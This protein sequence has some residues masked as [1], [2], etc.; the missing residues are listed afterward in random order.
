[1]SGFGLF[2]GNYVRQGYAYRW[3]VLVPAVVVF[4]LATVHVAMQPDTYES[5]AILM[6]PM[7]NSADREMRSEALSI[8]EDVFRSATERLTSKNVL[9][10]IS[11]QTDPYP[12]LR[13]TR[14]M[15]AVVE[16][17][18]RNLRI[19]VN[20]AAR[21]ITILCSQSD[22]DNAAEMAANV[23]KA[24]TD[25]FVR[26]QR[27]AIQGRVNELK[28]YYDTELARH[29]LSLDRARNARDEFK[30]QNAGA[31][32]DDRAANNVRIDGLKR[33]ISDFRL[34]KEA[35]EL[36][37]VVLEGDQKRLVT[38]LSIATKGPASVQSRLEQYE[39]DLRQARID[40]KTLLTVYQP[41]HERVLAA[42]AMIELLE[43]MLENARKKEQDPVK[44][45]T[46]F[47]NSRLNE[48]ELREK[49]SRDQLVKLDGRIANAEK[50]IKGLEAK[51][52]RA[53]E[54]E[55]R[56]IT[57][58]QTV[59]E[60]QFAYDGIVRRQNAAEQRARFDTFASMIPVQ[61]EQNAFV[62]NKP[63]RPDR[64]VTSVMGL[65]MGVGVGVGLAVVRAKLDNSYNRPDDLRSLLPG[66]VLVTVPDVRQGGTRL[67]LMVIG[68]LGGLVLASL[69][70]ATIGLLGL[71]IG[72]WGE[73][74]MVRDLMSL[75]R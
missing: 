50:E 67:G 27:D 46:D 10:E 54:I 9:Q 20:S 12:L 73:P 5:H 49:S 51:V 33:D 19:D 41:E 6:R 1:M 42:K 23:V 72:W 61:V 70:A 11:R 37:I 4:A 60:A 65:L 68:I 22:G 58:Q 62:P 40:H 7:A 47:L 26:Q 39:A 36:R 48:L 15:D 31:L 69:F 35:F 75:G 55:G 14:G 29:R 56:Y 74:E 28:H 16:R 43:A 71:Q 52:A 2:V 59:D 18:R 57:L 25:I 63:T 32:P 44:N 13:E 53:G 30:R 66:A 45:H 34:R 3:I 38:E 64:L 21:T 24:A 17:L 8:A